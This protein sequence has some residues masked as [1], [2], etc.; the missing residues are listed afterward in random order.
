MKLRAHASRR[1][2]RR[3]RAASYLFTQ[4]PAVKARLRKAPRVALF[5]DFDGTLT[6]LR[7]R[8]EDVWLAEPVR[9]LLARLNRRDRIAVHIVSGRRL[10]DVRARAGVAGIT[11]LG[12]HGWEREGKRLSELSRREL[13]SARK[14]IVAAIASWPAV[15]L[16]DKSFS[17]A[18]H[19]R[20]AREAVARRVRP[21]V[22]KAL[23]S[24]RRLKVLRGKKVLEVLPREMKG[25]GAA[26]RELLR[27]MP[28]GTLPVFVGDDV[29][30]E[31]AFRA[32]P[33]GL[34]VR[35][36][37]PRGTAAKYFLRSPAE[38]RRFLE[39]IE[40]TFGP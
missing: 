27:A 21:V 9:K 33:R 22:E 1:S 35:V 14:E 7:R 38:V 30:D 8:A 4:W 37:S 31:A 11:Y 39:R 18:V 3:R 15:R 20:G 5:L 12:V 29:T 36:G 17:F 40:E 25:K 32:L 28:S 19:Y 10:A 34:T 13:A 16:E 24:R 6:R 23:A 26:V 2:R